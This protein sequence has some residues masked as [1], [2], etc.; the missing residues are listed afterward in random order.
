M[1]YRVYYSGLYRDYCR[2][3]FHHSLL[4]TREFRVWFGGCGGGVGWGRD[5]GE[6]CPHYRNFRGSPATRAGDIF[7]TSPLWHPVLP[8]RFFYPI[9]GLRLR[10]L[11]RAT[12]IK[13]P[14][15][16][17]YTHVLVT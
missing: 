3:P 16:S 4:S 5:W 7:P 17:L 14:Y 6:T 10:N 9:A 8:T 11:N 15:C 13:K 1:D 12:M 2:D